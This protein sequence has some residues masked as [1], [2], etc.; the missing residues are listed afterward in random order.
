L[1]VDGSRRGGAGGGKTKGD[2]PHGT[3]F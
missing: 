2:M 3:S 1:G